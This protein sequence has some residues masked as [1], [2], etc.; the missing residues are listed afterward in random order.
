MCPLQLLLEDQLYAMIC[1]IGEVSARR[2]APGERAQIEALRRRAF[3]A[4]ARGDQP[5]TQPVG[6]PWSDAIWRRGFRV[7]RCRHYWIGLQ[8]RVVLGSRLG[9]L[10]A[11][12]HCHVLSRHRASVNDALHDFLMGQVLGRSHRRSPFIPLTAAG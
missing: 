7:R 12:E 3:Q 11:L 1:R 10:L 9:P 4:M 6:Q 8:E 2:S 5:A